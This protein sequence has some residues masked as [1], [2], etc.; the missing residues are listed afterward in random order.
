MELIF[1]FFFSPLSDWLLLPLP[2]LDEYDEYE[3]SDGLDEYDPLDVE[4]D[5]DDDDDDEGLAE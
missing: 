3:L 4:Y 1:F 2:L 5:D